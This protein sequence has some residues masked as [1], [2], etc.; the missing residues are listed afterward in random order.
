MKGTKEFYEIQADLERMI[1]KSPIYIGC[2]IERAA[3]DA[4]HFYENGKL[5][6]LFY[7]FMAGVSTGKII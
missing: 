4:K 7:V 3:K 1:E 6:E 5:N 2:K